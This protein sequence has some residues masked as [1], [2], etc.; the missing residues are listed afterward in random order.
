M[1]GPLFEDE[2]PQQLKD[3]HFRIRGCR[4]GSARRDF[5]RFLKDLTID[6]PNPELVV[7]MQNEVAFVRDA[8]A[9]SE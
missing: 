9:C 4:A 1:V 2:I 5:A 8:L 6:L 3:Y 7:I